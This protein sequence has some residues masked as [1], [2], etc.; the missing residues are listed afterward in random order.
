MK[1]HRRQLYELYRLKFLRE[2]LLSELCPPSASSNFHVTSVD[3]CPPFEDLKASLANVLQRVIQR[4][5]INRE[6]RHGFESKIPAVAWKSRPLLDGNL[7]GVLVNTGKKRVGGG[8]RV[9]ILRERPRASSRL[10]RGIYEHRDKRM[11]RWRVSPGPEKGA[12]RGWRRR[13]NRESSKLSSLPS[14]IPIV[15][16]WKLFRFSLI[17]KEKRRE[18]CVS[19]W[20]THCQRHSGRKKKALFLRLS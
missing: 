12:E 17:V 7:P 20:L 6:R 16:L 13:D 14:S 15:K 1:N 19:V 10:A 5:V 18:A 9:W 3:S 8:W 11:R 2:Y 4:E